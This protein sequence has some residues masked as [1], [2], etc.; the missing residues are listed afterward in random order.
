MA[1]QTIGRPVA[2]GKVPLID[3]EGSTKECGRQLGLTWT[4]ALHV[5]AHYADPERDAWWRDR[6]FSRLLDRYAPHLPS[7][8]KAIAK[9]A[10]LPEEKISTR[11]PALETFD[12]GA[13]GCT[14]FAIAPR[15]TLDGQCI[16]GQTKDTNFSRMLQ[17]QVLRLKLTDAPPALTVTYP[18]WLFG[19]GFVRGGC[20]I[21]RNSL[22]TDQGAAKGLPYAVWGMLA[23]HCATVQDVVELTRRHGVA[24]AAHCTVAD[25]HGGIV[26]LETAAGRCGVLKARRGIYTHANA[27]VSG[28]RLRPYEREDSRFS[29]KNSL[30]RE[31]RLRALL[32]ANRGRLTAQLAYCALCDHE[33]FPLSI[34]RSESLEAFTTAAIVSEPTRGRIHVTRGLPSQNWPVTYCL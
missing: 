30:F 11:A 20:A 19:H 23:L 15:A 7:L 26:G 16:S 1:R 18:G 10:G 3:L 6:R 31:N 17:Y 22:F 29:R 14:S 33:G 12:P 25:E 27:I 13:S 21:F 34:C 32:E 4:H 24:E 9:G 8:Y 2:E 28:K 5:G